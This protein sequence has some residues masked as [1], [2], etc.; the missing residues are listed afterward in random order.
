MKRK[1]NAPEIN[2]IKFQSADIITTSTEEFDG[3]WVRIV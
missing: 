2:L 1:Y 3:E